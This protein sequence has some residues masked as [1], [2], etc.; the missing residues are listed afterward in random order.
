MAKFVKGQSGNPGGVPKVKKEV[1]DLAKQYTREAVLRLAGLMRQQSDPGI[2]IKAAQLL[3]ERGWGKPQQ[4]VEKTQTT[5]VKAEVS[6][7][8][9]ARMIAF[10][11]TQAGKPVPD[12]DQ[13][14]KE[15]N[16]DPETS[17]SIQ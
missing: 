12:A 4:T 7:T 15:A 8:E 13:M 9:A 5:T 16:L 14:D 3:L 1:R 11:M 2:A 6:D 17:P 10:M